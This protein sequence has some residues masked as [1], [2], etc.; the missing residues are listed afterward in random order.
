[1]QEMLEKETQL[2]SA[3]GQRTPSTQKKTDLFL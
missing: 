2:I 1:M 3:Q